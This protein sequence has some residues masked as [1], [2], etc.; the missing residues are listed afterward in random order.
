MSEE[1]KKILKMLAE[2]KISADDADRLIEA[3]SLKDD[4]VLDKDD[5]ESVDFS[6]KGNPK[7]LR[8]KVASKNGDVVNIKVPLKLV[9]AGVKLGGVMPDGVKEKVQGK[10][11]EKGLGLNLSDL[12]GENIEPLLEALTESEIKIID[13]DEVVKIYCE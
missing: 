3:L 8:I 13:K 10:L 5:H 12:N 11:D 6:D 4:P 1:R 2:G 9:R 7:N